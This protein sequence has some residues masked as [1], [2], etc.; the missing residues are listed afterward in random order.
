[1]E[2]PVELGFRIRKKEKKLGNQREWNTS[3]VNLKLPKIQVQCNV[4][5]V[6]INHISLFCWC[7]LNITWHLWKFKNWWWKVLI[8]DTISSISNFTMEA[9]ACYKTFI[10][11]TKALFWTIKVSFKSSFKN[12]TGL[13]LKQLT[14]A[15]AYQ[16]DL[17]RT[18]VTKLIA[19]RTTSLLPQCCKPRQKPPRVKSSWRCSQAGQPSVTCKRN[20]RNIRNILNWINTPRSNAG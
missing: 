20:E 4:S 5:S 1:M 15:G 12:I 10:G 19:T 14:I 16:W 2:V 18:Y 9:R 7:K 13:Q 3:L 6:I 8:L 11:W 17:V